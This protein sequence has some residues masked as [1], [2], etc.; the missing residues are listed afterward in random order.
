MTDGGPPTSVTSDVQIRLT[1]RSS[2]VPDSSVIVKAVY[3]VTPRPSWLLKENRIVSAGSIVALVGGGV[4]DASA[5]PRVDGANKMT[6]ITIEIATIHFPRA[7]EPFVIRY[8]W[9]SFFAYL[10]ERFRKNVWRMMPMR[11]ITRRGGRN[12]STGMK[13]GLAL[14]PESARATAMSPEVPRMRPAVVHARIRRMRT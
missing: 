3:R 11:N 14:A 1:A 13:S 10:I 2:L 6:A 8:R 9:L 4:A 5:A 12:P 7:I